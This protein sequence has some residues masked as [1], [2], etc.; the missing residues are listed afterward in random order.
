MNPV[1]YE[2]DEREVTPAMIEAG[3]KAYIQHASHDEMSFST[4]EETVEAILLA[5]LSCRGS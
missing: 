1:G 2:P 3:V 4:R 5:A